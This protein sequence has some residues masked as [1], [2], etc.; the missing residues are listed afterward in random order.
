MRR[1][2]CRH[3]GCDRI[4]VKGRHVGAAPTH[5]RGHIF[6]G[7]ELGRTLWSHTETF[8]RVTSVPTEMEQS[9]TEPL[10][11]PET[12]VRLFA[13]AHNALTNAFLHAR[14]NRVGSIPVGGRIVR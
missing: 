2:A 9:G 12:R 14:A 11:A 6:E 13:I 5:G 1:R 10:L 4:P 7:R 3:A 8:S